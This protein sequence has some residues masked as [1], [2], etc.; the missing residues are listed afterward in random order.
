MRRC[1]LLQF[2]ADYPSVVETVAVEERP[3][4][5][6]MIVPVI[7]ERSVMRIVL[8][9]SYKTL[10]QAPVPLHERIS[11]KHTPRQTVA[12]YTFSGSASMERSL[13]KLSKLH[14]LIYTDG[15][16]TSEKSSSRQE[17]AVK[18]V[19]NQPGLEVGPTLK[20]E[21]A[22]D[23]NVDAEVNTAQSNSTPRWLLAQY[24]PPYTLPFLRRNEIWVPLSGDNPAVKELLKGQ[25]KQVAAACERLESAVQVPEYGVLPQQAGEK[26]GGVPMGEEAKLE[27]AAGPGVH[28]SFDDPYAL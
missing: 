8:P 18:H 20:V 24:N 5:V 10:D 15:L 12:V 22:K 23:E 1:D 3:E 21:G 26:E 16:L 13:K 9:P 25:D 17:G 28:V 6:D 11:I 7:K 27:P 4:S 19:P 2:N 14:K